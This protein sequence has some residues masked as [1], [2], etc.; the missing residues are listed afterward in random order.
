LKS[1][2][3]EGWLVP[4]HE[5]RKD[6]NRFHYKTS[7]KSP[8][9]QGYL[10]KHYDGIKGFSLLGDRLADLE[11]TLKITALGPQYLYFLETKLSWGV[12]S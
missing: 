9:R 6:L 11:N 4:T 8:I 3:V 5:E 1:E 7:Y 12:L 2:L 10:D